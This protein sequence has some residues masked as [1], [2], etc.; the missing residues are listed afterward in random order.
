MNF[1]DKKIY[2]AGH[3][4]MV[5]SA[6]LRKLSAEGYDSFVLRTS[7]ELD[8]SNQKAVNDFLKKKKN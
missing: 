8:L 2:I 1:Q 4:G 6:V 3:T 5:G 7:K